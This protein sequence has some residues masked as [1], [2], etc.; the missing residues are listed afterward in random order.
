MSTQALCP[1][2]PQLLKMLMEACVP[3]PQPGQGRGSLPR[4]TALLPKRPGA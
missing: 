4:R 3:V 2:S 1:D